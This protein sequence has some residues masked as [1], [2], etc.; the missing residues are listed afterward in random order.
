M[1]ATLVK[2]V[3][4][5]ENRTEIELL[6]SLLNLGLCAALNSGCLTIEE[7]E[8]YLYSPYTLEQLEK[9]GVDRELIDLIQLGTELEDVQSLISEKLGDSIEEIQVG[10]IKF[11][12]SL[13]LINVPKNKWIKA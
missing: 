1:D 7:A 5:L 3:I 10:T 4:Q 8:I 9:L 13:A 11:L 2:T 6:I 12:K